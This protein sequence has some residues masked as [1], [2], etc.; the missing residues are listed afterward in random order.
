[1][2]S[3]RVDGAARALQRRVR[4]AGEQAPAP[5]HQSRVELP[6]ECRQGFRTIV[7]PASWCLA[8]FTGRVG[9]IS[10]GRDSAVLTL[11][12]RLVLEAQRRLEPVAWI[13]GR[14]RAFYPPDVAAVAVDLESLVVVW[15]SDALPAARAA[16]QL[17]RSG[18]FGLLV[19]DLGRGGRLSAP[20][21]ARLG[22][23]AK[24]HEAAILCLTEKDAGNPSVGG[25]ISVRAQAIRSRQQG[26][27]RCRAQILKDKRRGPGWEHVELCHGPAG[28]H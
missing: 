8:A 27:F 12:F 4:A 15:A 10:G 19:L 3:A 1:M 22:G 18:A 2:H 5:P 17:V 23:L 24:K 28:L 25:L 13:T 14:D 6:E 16:D 26:S 9:E 11:T 21:L 20:V 7:S